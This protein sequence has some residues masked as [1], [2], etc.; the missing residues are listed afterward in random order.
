MRVAEG[1][2][3]VGRGY[4]GATGRGGGTA[5]KRRG[6]G[7]SSTESWGPL[8]LAIPNLDGVFSGRI[9]TGGGG[10]EMALPFAHF[11]LMW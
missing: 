1:G 2:G 11:R 3:A 7:E 10:A 6:K 5:G 8:L 9:G 4:G